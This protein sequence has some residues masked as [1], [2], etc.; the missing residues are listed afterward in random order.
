MKKHKLDNFW[1]GFIL[2]LIGAVIGFFLYGLIWSN[3]NGQT[4]AYF[5]NDVFIGTSFL[6]DKLVTISVLFDVLLFFIF[7]KFNW[8]NLC[9]GLLAVVIIAVPVAIYFY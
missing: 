6:T 7:M 3:V 9:K 4:L 5:V 8:Y 1:V 2:G